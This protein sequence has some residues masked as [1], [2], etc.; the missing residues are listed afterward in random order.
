MVKTGNVR[1]LVKTARRSNVRC[2]VAAMAMTSRG[3]IICYANNQ[4]LG[5]SKQ[6]TIHAEEALLKKLHR[7]KAYSRY[8]RITIFVLRLGKY[9]ELRI[10]KPCDMCHNLL[11]KYGDMIDVLYTDDKGMISR[12]VY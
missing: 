1:K 10:A 3:G 2:Q 9:G 4:R 7:I 12:L 8:D 5:S 6:K 11:K